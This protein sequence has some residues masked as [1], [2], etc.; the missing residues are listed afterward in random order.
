MFH[1]NLRKYDYDIRTFT[2]EREIGFGQLR[3]HDVVLMN[4][5]FFQRPAFARKCS[6]IVAGN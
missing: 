4:T 3:K 2:S 5:S 1:V 6:D